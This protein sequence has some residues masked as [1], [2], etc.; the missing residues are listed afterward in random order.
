MIMDN[1]SCI[2]IARDGICAF[3]STNSYK[4][5]LAMRPLDSPARSLGSPACPLVFPLYRPRRRSSRWRP[6]PPRRSSPS[7][8]LNLV[9]SL[10]HLVPPPP[11]LLMAFFTDRWVVP[12]LKRWQEASPRSI[13]NCSIDSQSVKHTAGPKSFRDIVV[14]TPP[15][16]RVQAGV[17]H[18]PSS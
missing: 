1:Y 17:C 10:R 11:C 2:D 7:A 4:N 16:P 3:V 15:A 9:V 6:L 12:R 8:R 18:A 13:G 5:T 14:S